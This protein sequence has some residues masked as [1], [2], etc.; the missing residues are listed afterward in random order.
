MFLNNLANRHI[1]GKTS[2]ILSVSITNVYMTQF[3]RIHHLQIRN[4]GLPPYNNAG[5][6]DSYSKLY[7]IAF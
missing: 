6:K 4:Y 7:K 3:H 5:Y 1:V 2:Y